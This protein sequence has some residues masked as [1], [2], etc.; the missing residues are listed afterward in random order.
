M[1]AKEKDR[2]EE[3]WKL[4][5]YD[6]KFEL[7]EPHYPDSPNGP[8]LTEADELWEMMDWE[9]RYEVY[10]AED[11][12]PELT[13]QEQADIRGDREAHRIMVEGREI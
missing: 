5:D 3:W 10:C 2:I 12:E 4:L 9:K 11:D 1:N 7:V 8:I 13:E 6:H